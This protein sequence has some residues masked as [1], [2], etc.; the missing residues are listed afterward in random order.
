MTKISLE[1]FIAETLKSISIG[2]RRAQD[3]S[4]AAKGVPIGLFSVGGEKTTTGEQLVCFSVSVEVSEEKSGSGAGELK[5]PLI[6]IV[7]VG[8]S[9]AINQATVDKSVHTIEFKVP[10]HFNSRWSDES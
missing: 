6:S 9:G 10:M 5:I 8:V 2:V 4:K 7:S 1:T 3:E